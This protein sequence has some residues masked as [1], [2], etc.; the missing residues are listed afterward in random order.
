MHRLHGGLQGFVQ[1][2]RAQIVGRLQIEPRLRVA[3]KK[4]TQAQGCIGVDILSGL[5]PLS[6][7]TSAE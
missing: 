2:C 3:T 7:P 4:P 5:N 6:L 1:L